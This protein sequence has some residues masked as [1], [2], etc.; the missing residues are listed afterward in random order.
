MRLSKLTSLAMAAWCTSI[1]R[2]REKMSMHKLFVRWTLGF[3]LLCGAGLIARSP[4]A[5]TW[6]DV[7][8]CM[9]LGCVMGAA[10]VE[11]IAGDE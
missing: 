6:A 2:E 1:G 10:L 7:I 3:S 5:I 9:S 8:T 4:T 11:F